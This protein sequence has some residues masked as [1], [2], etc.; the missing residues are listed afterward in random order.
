MEA[1]SDIA[2][3]YLDDFEILRDARLQLESELATWWKEIIF[4]GILPKLQESSSLELDKWDIQGNPGC[5]QIFIKTDKTFVLTIQDPRSSGIS[6]YRMRV[7]TIKPK[8]K[9]LSQNA[10]MVE[11][12]SKIATTNKTNP[13]FV[14]DICLAELNIEFK[15]STPDK[16]LKELIDGAMRLFKLIEYLAKSEK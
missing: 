9:S 11:E 7:E 14:S 2:K 16:T 8:L 1:L 12:L 4:T 3:S 13:L 15:S 5:A 10:A 6:N